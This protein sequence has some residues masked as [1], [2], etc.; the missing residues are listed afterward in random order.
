MVSSSFGSL[1]N[2]LETI[3]RFRPAMFIESVLAEGDWL[4]PILEP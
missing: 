2:G 4:Y 1:G 3:E